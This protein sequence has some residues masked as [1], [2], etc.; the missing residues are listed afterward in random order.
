MVLSSL[1]SN[2][3]FLSNDNSSS[4]YDPSKPFVVLIHGLHQSARTMSPLAA[5]L[6]SKGFST[7]QHDYDS[8]GETLDQHSDNLHTWL[9]DNHDPKVPINFV[10]HSL[11]GLV[12]RN[13]ITRYPQWNIGRCVTLG[14]PHTGSI[15]AKYIKDL[16][17]PLIGK[18]YEQSLDGNIAPLE[19]YICMG[20]IAGDAPDNFSQI[21]LIYHEHQAKLAVD[22]RAHDGAVFVYET[23][24]PNAADHIILPVSHME[25]LVD[26]EVAQQTAYFIRHGKFDR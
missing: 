8:L 17:P 26:D 3:S 21:V 15:K 16:I 12:V 14:T 11:G 10:G 7:Y 22:E 23:L 5:Q 2:S 24:L 13:F 25:M 19:E 18:S 1:L 4:S 9:V 6:Q 20:V